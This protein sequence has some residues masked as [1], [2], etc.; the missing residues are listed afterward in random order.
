MRK[1]NPDEMEVALEAIHKE[2]KFLADRLA[3]FQRWME[4]Y[5]GSAPADLPDFRGKE[6]DRLLPEVIKKIKVEKYVSTSFIQ[7]TFNVG[8][9]RSARIIDELY[10]LGYIGAAQGSKPRVVLKKE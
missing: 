2:I 9:V 5:V 8:Y 3:K 1:L 4:C 10:A 6:P 7:R